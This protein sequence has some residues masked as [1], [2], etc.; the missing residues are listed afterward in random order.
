MIATA[1]SWRLPPPGYVL[2]PEGGSRYLWFGYF[3]RLAYIASTIFCD[4]A[5]SR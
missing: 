2:Y 1:Y 5:S 4:A 3:D